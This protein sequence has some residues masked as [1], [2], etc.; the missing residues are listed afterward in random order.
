MTSVKMIK[1]SG[2][3]V[4]VSREQLE[5][6]LAQYDSPSDYSTHIAFAT[7]LHV[8]FTSPRSNVLNPRLRAGKCWIK[9]DGSE[10]NVGYAFMDVRTLDLTISRLQDLRATLV[11]D[12][13]N[14]GIVD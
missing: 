13:K 2:V 14:H 9:I 10:E 3:E 12:K 8:K 6:A 11:L 7:N 1:L 5:D 4:L